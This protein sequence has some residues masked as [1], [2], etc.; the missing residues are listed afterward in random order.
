VIGTDGTSRDRHFTGD[1]HTY[2]RSLGCCGR[3]HDA[4]EMKNS[5]SIRCYVLKGYGKHNRK[6]TGD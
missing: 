6:F 1:S 5:I 3:L 4:V 2:Q